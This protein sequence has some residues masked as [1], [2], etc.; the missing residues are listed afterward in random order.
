M[1]AMIRMR[2][3]AAV[4]WLSAEP[5]LGPM[6]VRKWLPHEREV[7]QTR[8]KFYP[9]LDW[10]VAG[11]ESGADARPMHPAWARQ[12]RDECAAAGVPFHFKQWGEWGPDDHGEKVHRFVMTHPN[13]VIDSRMVRMF[14]SGKKAAG[15]LLD[16]RTHDDMPASYAAAG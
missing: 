13:V 8:S 15:R 14:R 2:K 11:G 3:D 6:Y 4:L 16:G 5:L 9:G 10:V 1:P 12:L 7:S